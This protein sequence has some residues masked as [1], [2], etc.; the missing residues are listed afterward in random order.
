LFVTA[1]LGMNRMVHTSSVHGESFG[2]GPSFDTESQD[3][4]QDQSVQGESVTIKLLL[5]EDEVSSTNRR[6]KP[7]SPIH[8]KLSPDFPNPSFELL[9]PYPFPYLPA[10]VEYE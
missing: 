10:L 9:S 5:V 6:I 1:T 4:V 8:H 2:A 3:E 7:L